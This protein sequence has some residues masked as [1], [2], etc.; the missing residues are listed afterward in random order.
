[1]LTESKH[2]LECLSKG[3]YFVECLNNDL[4]CL[5]ENHFPSFFVADSGTSDVISLNN[6]F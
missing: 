3:I 2:S 6:L 5:L 1:M 4:T